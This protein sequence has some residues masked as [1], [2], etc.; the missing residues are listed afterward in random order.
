MIREKNDVDKGENVDGENIK[1]LESRVQN[2]SLEES[3]EKITNKIVEDCFPC[4]DTDFI[5][6]LD[7]EDPVTDRDRDAFLLL[8]F[9]DNCQK[10]PC[11][12]LKN[13]AGDKIFETNRP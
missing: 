4:V 13:L 5:E 12:E 10:E 8:Y 7:Y 6:S 11:S 3:G 9:S 2:I 1:Y